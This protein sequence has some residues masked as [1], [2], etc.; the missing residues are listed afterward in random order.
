[1]CPHS[2]AEN[3]GVFSKNFQNSPAQSLMLR[4]KSLDSENS[5]K[6]HNQYEHHFYL[7]TAAGK[8][9]RFYQHKRTQE[10]DS[11]RHCYQHKRT[12]E[13]TTVMEEIT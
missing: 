8:C 3:G 11:T 9:L 7:S 12:P 4:S 5:Q 6:K 10:L 1:M 13:D 2:H